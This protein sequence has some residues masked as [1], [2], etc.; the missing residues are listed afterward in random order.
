MVTGAGSGLGRAIARELLGGGWQ[1]AVAG[2]RAQP[3]HDTVTGGDWPAD[4]ALVVPADV[5]V[6]ESVAELFAA[7]T[8]RW[9]RLDLL[10]NNAGV[11]GPP[12]A[13]D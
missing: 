13:V 1:V 6:P 2:R 12:G 9:G 7:V 10:V 4:A 8:S 5:T 3:L 11:F